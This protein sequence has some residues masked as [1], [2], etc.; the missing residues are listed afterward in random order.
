MT[1]KAVRLIKSA[2]VIAIPAKDRESCVAFGIA[3]AAVKELWEKE[4]LPI[5]F[6]MTKDEAVLAA[7]H[8]KGARD[9]AA[10][11]DTG[12]DVAFLT[13]GDPTVY[14]TYLYLHERLTAMGYASEIVSGVPSFC[15]AAARLSVSLGE[16]AESIHILPGSYPV[17]E[18]LRLPGTKVL[19]KSGRQIRSVKE[20]LL[21]CG[22][23]AMM[24]EKCGMEGERLAFAARDIPEDAGYYTLLIVKDG[25]EDAVEGRK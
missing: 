12:R 20:A 14:S 22:M 19:M 6:P 23:E 17:E 3:A 9:V 18:G 10:V 7:S 4:F 25:E 21:A 8:E 13:L 24:A 1:L 16:K 11:L 15:A 2:D 5:I